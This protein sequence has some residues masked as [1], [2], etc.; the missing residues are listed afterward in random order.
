MMTTTSRRSVS[1]VGVLA[2][3]SPALGTTAADTPRDRRIFRHS[4]N[5]GAILSF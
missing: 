3:L 1:L 5:L 4:L 2:V